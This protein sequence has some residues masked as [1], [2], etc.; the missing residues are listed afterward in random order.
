VYNAGMFNTALQAL[1]AEKRVISSRLQTDLSMSHSTGRSCRTYDDTSDYLETESESASDSN[2]S[3]RHHPRV[4]LKNVSASNDH[5]NDPTV[6]SQS[7]RGGPTM[8][9]YRHSQMYPNGHLP[10]SESARCEH[11][12]QVPPTRSNAVESWTTSSNHD[13]GHGYNVRNSSQ[14]EKNRLASAS[15]QLSQLLSPLSQSEFIRRPCPTECFDAP[16]LNSSNYSSSCTTN[17]RQHHCNPKSSL[18]QQSTSCPPTRT[19]RTSATPKT[20]RRQVLTQLLYPPLTLEKSPSVE[21]QPV[22]G[23]VGRCR[24]RTTH[25]SSPDKGTA[26]PTTSPPNGASPFSSSPSRIAYHPSFNGAHGGDS[27]GSSTSNISN[28]TSNS[29]VVK[30][31]GGGGHY[32]HDPMAIT[33]PPLSTRAGLSA[34]AW[35]AG[36]SQVKTLGM[37]L[38]GRKIYCVVHQQ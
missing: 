19:S 22:G 16:L 31:G 18:F 29:G 33:L 23:V 27:S 28:F 35:D 3:E 34:S 5:S 7:F 8:I 21:R 37:L 17:P 4:K 30:R 36:Y 6:D 25:S 13:N 10:G 14:S 11:Q 38:C 32:D 20:R 24:G 2:I 26:T 15:S 1:S 12:Y 9:N